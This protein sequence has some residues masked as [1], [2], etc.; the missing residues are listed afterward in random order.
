[1]ADATAATTATA[2]PD[3]T[4]AN[5]NAAAAAAT[6]AS[7]VISPVNPRSVTM[8]MAPQDPLAG[9]AAPAAAPAATPAAPAAAPAAPGAAKAPAAA[10]PAAPAAAD[11]KAAADTKPEDAAA[12]KI[13]DN[14]GLDYQAI[15]N[16]YQTTGY[17]KPE[18]KDALR[19]A[20]E[21]AGLPPELVDQY[22]VN[23]KAQEALLVNKAYEIAGGKDAYEE[24]GAWAR[25][26]LTPEEIETFSSMAKTGSPD[27]ALL[28]VKLLHGQWRQAAME[29]GQRMRA[30]SG[31]SGSGSQSKLF[32]SMAE[33]AE[34]QK[35]PNYAISPTL[36]REVQERLQRS[37]A[38][39]VFK[40]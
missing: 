5:N 33:L 28:A 34:A 7:A 25:E 32:H 31:S 40:G 20:V 13:V 8:A 39:G 6:V 35:D 18:T 26:N 9:A 19:K 23:L 10:A 3:P 15:V 1:M 27:Q 29:G 37:I 30:S 16:E 14:A 21:K 24:M 17:I 4:A 2:G 11:D 12:K 38:A 22:F 36:Q